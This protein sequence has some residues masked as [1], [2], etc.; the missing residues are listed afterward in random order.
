[1]GN[2]E[3]ALPSIAAEQFVLGY[4]L[5]QDYQFM[6]EG[7]QKHEE[8]DLGLDL[9]DFFE[10][11]SEFDHGNYAIATAMVGL[12]PYQIYLRSYQMSSKKARIQ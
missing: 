6:L 11:F 1:M 12:F 7:Q 2:E 4:S 10:Y 9:L 8:L 5:E 3:G